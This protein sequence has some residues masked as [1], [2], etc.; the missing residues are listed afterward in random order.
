MNYIENIFVCLAAPLLI[1]LICTRG[2]GKRMVLFLLSGMAACLLSSYIST[3]IAA[4]QGAD[5]FSHP[6][7]SRR[8]WKRR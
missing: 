3:F 4:I 1:A 7:R 8:S 2:K 5:L 6:W